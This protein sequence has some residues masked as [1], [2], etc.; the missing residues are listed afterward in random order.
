MSLYGQKQSS[1]IPAKT[2]LLREELAS[3][4]LRMPAQAANG[5]YSRMLLICFHYF[6]RIEDCSEADS[7][8]V[9]LLSFQG[10]EA[11]YE[12]KKTNKTFGNWNVSGRGR[13]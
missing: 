5:S 8:N 4:C 10:N 11:F 6:Q 9:S 1:S 2:V 13:F 12:M 7:I 3:Q